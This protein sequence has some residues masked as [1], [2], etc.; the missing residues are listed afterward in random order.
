MDLKG[1]TI[2]VTGGAGGIGSMLCEALR[3]KGATVGIVDR[4][5]AQGA[6][7]ADLSTLPGIVSAGQSIAEI[8]PDILINLAGITYFG[9]FEKES[10][11]HLSALMHVNLIAP[12]LLSQAV[13]PG[14]KKRAKGMIVNIGSVF[15]AI[16]FAY[17]AAYSS[18]KAGLRGLS[19]ALRRE[20]EDTGIH[21]VHVAPRAVKT[22][23][24][25]A[26]VMALAAKTNMKMDAP[27]VVV[28]AII[29]AM[30]SNTPHTVVGFPEKLFVRLHGMS[31]TMIDGGVRKQN[32]AAKTILTQPNV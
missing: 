28:R 6:L 10:P 26:Q 12:T 22:A 15:G 16:P 13:I 7:A 8:Q 31:S 25:N 18:S 30:E 23:L 4:S 14:M 5:D 32:Q 2:I 9:E 21:V 29:T 3:S 20:L 27:D 19:D 17:F 24:N 11:E 1:K